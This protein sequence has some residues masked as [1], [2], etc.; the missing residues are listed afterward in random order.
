M[1]KYTVTGGWNLVD[2]GFIGESRYDQSRYD[3][4]VSNGEKSSASSI[5][6]AMMDDLSKEDLLDLMASTMRYTIDAIWRTENELDD[7]PLSLKDTHYLGRLLDRAD[8]EKAPKG[9]NSLTMHQPEL[10]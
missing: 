2:P 6:R 5:S 8:K 3:L 10:V 4:I 7:A 1:K 9:A